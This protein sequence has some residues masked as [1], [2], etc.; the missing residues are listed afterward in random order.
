MKKKNMGGRRRPPTGNDRRRPEYATC[1]GVCKR[2]DTLSKCKIF[3][4]L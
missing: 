3:K 4:Y 2:L 1:I